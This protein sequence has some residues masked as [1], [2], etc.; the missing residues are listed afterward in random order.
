MKIIRHVSV[1]V[2]VVCL[3]F[4]SAT[5]MLAA[6]PVQKWVFQTKNVVGSSPAIGPDGTI[7]V[8]SEDHHLYAIN[9]DGTRKWAFETGK[10]VLSS[11]AIGPDG[12][13]YIGSNDGKLYAINQNGSLKWAFSTGKAV[14]SSPAI[15]SDG[16]IY[17]ASWDHCIYAINADG[18][19]KWAF[20][21]GGGVFSSPAIGPDGTIYVGSNDG[22]LYAIKGSEGEIAQSSPISKGKVSDVDSLRGPTE[23]PADAERII[24]KSP[25]QE[26]PAGEIFKEVK[27]IR[28]EVTPE[29]D[30]KVSFVLSGPYLPET[31]AIE[32]D[33]P[34]MVCDFLGASLGDGAADKV[35]PNG[36]LVQQIRTGVHGGPK[37]KVRVVID[38]APNVDYNVQPI[39]FKDRHLYVLVFTPR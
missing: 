8:G 27:E 4:L 30:E 2:L 17:V 39:F 3:G 11:P 38:L 21:T 10:G 35:K 19:R 34:R 33:R 22:K 25:E 6:G 18:T 20:K 1:G 32:G 13:I 9:P 15:G 12:T 26:G 5:D 16:T 37:S 28:F 24:S 14:N 23:L 29:K 31:F 7:Y 36:R